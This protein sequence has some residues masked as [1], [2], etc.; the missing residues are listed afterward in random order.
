MLLRPARVSAICLHAVAAAV[1]E[2][3]FRVRAQRGGEL[4]GVGDGR[5]DEVDGSGLRGWRVAV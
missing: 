5:V 2:M 3:D 4:L 1:E